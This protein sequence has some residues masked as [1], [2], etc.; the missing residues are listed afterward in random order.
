MRRMHDDKEVV[1]KVKVENETLIVE[2][3][4]GESKSYPL[5]GGGGSITP[6]T[7]VTVLEGSETVVVDINET[8]DKVQV[9]LDQDVLDDIDAKA[10]IEDLAD[11]AFSGDYDDLANKPTI[12]VVPTNV[13]EFTNDAGYIT[14]AALSSYRTSA[15]QDIIDANKAD[16]DD[17]PTA[18]SDLT[19]DSGFITAS[20]IPESDIFWAT[21][22]TTPY[23]EI[24]AAV[25]DGKK[26]FCIY[27]DG[28]HGNEIYAFS[29]WDGSGVLA[30]NN[31]PND[32]NALRT[33]T[34]MA[35]YITVN[36][37]DEWTYTE[38]RAYTSAAVDEKVAAKSTVSVSATGTAT[39]EVGY[40]T[41]DGVEKKLPSGGGG[42]SYTFTNGLT[43]SSGTVS[44]DLNDNIKRESNNKLIIST[45]STIPSHT[46]INQNAAYIY[47]R[48]YD[49]GLCVGCYSDGGKI[50]LDHADNFNRSSTYDTNHAMIYG[51]SNYTWNTGNS[52][53]ELSLEDYSSKSQ[54]SILRFESNVAYP[55]NG[56]SNLYYRSGGGSSGYNPNCNLGTPDYKFNNGYFNGNI[57]A[58]NIPAAPTSDGNYVL[59]CS[60]VDGVATYSW[61][62]QA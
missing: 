2:N 28:Y 38:K 29:G 25:E 18:T 1:S 37:D 62:V 48:D 55:T 47:T 22:N 52:A 45:S 44:W 31:I 41:I 59:K 4:A 8:D 15:A 43:E 53:I 5:G 60:I 21:Y 50:S 54:N 23:A 24:S 13:S 7:L 30:F 11:V 12:P 6:E 3:A 46:N 51:T 26:L 33:I 16:T 61:E 14:N 20:D 49:Q 9:K 17:I 57:L 19:N 32:T 40:I 39:D 27:N 36:P 58:N 56:D 10:A 34:L 42:S 35:S